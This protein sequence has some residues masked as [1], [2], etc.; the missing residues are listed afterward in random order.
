MSPLK[1]EF[2]IASVIDQWQQV[3][4]TIHKH[5]NPDEPLDIDRA[6]RDLRQFWNVLFRLPCRRRMYRVLPRCGVP[7]AS[8]QCPT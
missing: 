8:H 5:A 3:L 4:G 2:L 7:S 6:A 1:P